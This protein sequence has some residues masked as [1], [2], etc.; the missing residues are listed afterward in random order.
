MMRGLLDFYL[1]TGFLTFDL[2]LFRALD[3]FS[4]VALYVDHPGQC[5]IGLCGPRYR[6]V[7]DGEETHKWCAER[8]MKGRYKCDTPTGPGAPK[9]KCACSFEDRPGI[10][11]E[12]T[13]M[14]NPD[15]DF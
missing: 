4:L 11:L 9:T 8:E 7:K 1:T 6:C 5:V 12:P 13:L 3:L 14:E 2:K 15:D 10:S